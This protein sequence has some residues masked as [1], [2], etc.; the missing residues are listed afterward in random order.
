MSHDLLVLRPAWHVRGVVKKLAALFVV[1]MVTCLCGVNRLMWA[2]VVVR[3][4]WN[5]NPPSMP[6]IAEYKYNVYYI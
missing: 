1:L 4:S 2:H 5:S 6:I 3:S